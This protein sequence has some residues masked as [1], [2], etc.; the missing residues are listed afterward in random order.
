MDVHVHTYIY[1]HTTYIAD[2][3]HLISNLLA[4]HEG[5]EKKRE[6]SSCS[7]L[8]KKEFLIWSG[9]GYLSTGRI[10]QNFYY[11]H[12]L[13]I[14]YPIVEEA[15]EVCFFLLL[16]IIN[17][18]YI[19]RTLQVCRF[20]AD[21]RLKAQILHRPATSSTTEVRLWA[22]LTSDNYIW[23][24]YR[25]GDPTKHPFEICGKLRQNANSENLT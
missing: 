8:L 5:N 1:I 7:F 17:Q 12:I 11:I 23:L 13:Y 4:N 9:S 15:I 2:L 20:V 16:E 14:S 25:K 21:C 19:M 22:P 6:A 10:G 3:S 24:E 18:K